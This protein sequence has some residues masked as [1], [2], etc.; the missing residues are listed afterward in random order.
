MLATNRLA[1]IIPEA[2]LRNPFGAGTQMRDAPLLLNIEQIS[3]EVQSRGT[4]GP[5]KRHFVL[6]K[7]FFKKSSFE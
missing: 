4:S 3:S 6:Q 5:T 2:N 7:F 1:G